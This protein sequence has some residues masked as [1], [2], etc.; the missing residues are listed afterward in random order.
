M[1]VILVQVA[2]VE[3]RVVMGEAVVMVTGREQ[4]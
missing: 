3:V 4:W 2:M 1:C